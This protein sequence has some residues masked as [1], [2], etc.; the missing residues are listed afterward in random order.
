MAEDK[1]QWCRGYID[2]EWDAND[3]LLATISYRDHL[4]DRLADEE[5]KDYRISA[6]V[7]EIEARLRIVRIID[8]PPNDL[9]D[10][11]GEVVAALSSPWFSRRAQYEQYLDDLKL[12]AERL[13]HDARREMER[14][15]TVAYCHGYQRLA[16]YT[17]PA[18]APP[19]AP[20]PAITRAHP[21]CHHRRLSWLQMPG[22]DGRPQGERSLC[23]HS[24][25]HA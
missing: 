12:L 23:P 10:P 13:K 7:Q 6:T 18:L 5:R 11:R 9:R 20:Y 14:L 21:L 1:A 17:R 3:L 15:L 16:P 19:P 24:A 22:F 25:D 8:S 2:P 4:D